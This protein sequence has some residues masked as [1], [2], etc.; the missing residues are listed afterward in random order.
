[1]P[2]AI[3]KVKSKYDDKTEYKVIK[4]TSSSSGLLTQSLNTDTDAS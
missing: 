1:M 2:K 4:T 3:L